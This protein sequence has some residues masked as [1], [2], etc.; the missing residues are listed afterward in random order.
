MRVG[1]G[2]I[3]GEKH[4]VWPSSNR[5][6]VWPFKGGGFN[7]FGGWK[8][9]HIGFDGQ[10]LDVSRYGISRYTNSILPYVAAYL[11]TLTS[12]Q[13]LC[14]QLYRGPIV[15]LPTKHSVSVPTLALRSQKLKRGGISIRVTVITAGINLLQLPINFTVMGL[16]SPFPKMH[17]AIWR[18]GPDENEGPSKRYFQ[19]Y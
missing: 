10:G 15:L 17:L 19:G 9:F 16:T 2:S 6:Y 7:L 5:T 11:E 4:R 1:W 18:N 12:V 14:S 3:G 13:P 8:F